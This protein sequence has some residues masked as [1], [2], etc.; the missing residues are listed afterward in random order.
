VKRFAVKTTPVPQIEIDQFNGR[1]LDLS[2]FLFDKQLAF[3]EDPAPFKVAVCSR[4]AGKTIACAAHLMRTALDNPDSVCLYITLSGVSGKRII[5]KEFT[6]LLKQFGIKAKTNDLELSITFPNGAVV[7][8]AGAKDASEIEKFRGLALKLVYI[9][10]CQSF[11][12][13]IQ[14]LIDDIIGPALMDYAGSLCLIGTPG[15][16]PTGYFYEC[17]TSP[18]WAKHHWTFWDNPHIPVKAKMTHQAVF[19]RE[20]RR[21]G[22]KDFA[23]PSVQR[24]WFGKWVNDTE[25]LLFKYDQVKNHFDF[26]P[27]APPPGYSYVLGVDIGHDDADALAVLAWSENSP[28]T[29]LVEEK[30]ESKQGITELVEQIEDIRKRYQISKIVMDTGGLGKKIAEEMIRRYLI[31]VEAADKA[32]KMENVELLNDAMRSGRFMAKNKSHFAHDTFLI[33]KDKDKSRPDKIVVS[34]RFHSD[35]ADAVLYAF[36]LSP[37]YSYQEPK[38]KPKPGTKE[39]ADQEHD[40]MFEAELE[41]MLAEEQWKQEYGN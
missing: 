25:S 4:R 37:A 23:E 14:D 26:L 10:E 21:R 19:D 39:W 9:D 28:I 6:K 18:E 29:Y 1:K 15:P 24:E 33:E 41:G 30:V 34:D 27:D 2:A 22:I 31:P 3:V 8:V 36:K 5:W 32:R 35:I 20:M 38:P 17:A 7:Y 13:Y 16:I 11:R 12:A 40:R